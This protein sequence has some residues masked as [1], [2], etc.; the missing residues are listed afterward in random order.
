MPTQPIP[1]VTDADVDRIAHR[2]FGVE[3]AQIVLS[4]L[5]KYGP[6]NGPECPRVRV[7]ILRLA[8]GDLTRI[9]ECVALALQ[10]Y[11][12]VI[13]DAEMP[14]YPWRSND[15]SRSQQIINRDWK[16]YCTWFEAKTPNQSTDPTLASVTPAAKQPAR[17]P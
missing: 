10:D 1:K 16:A 3:H 6:E 4:A 14:N 5:S 8:L 9:S 7:G 15:E 13:M 17:L 11:R 12:D 2:D